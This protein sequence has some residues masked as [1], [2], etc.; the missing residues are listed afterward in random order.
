MD[1]RELSG[2]S[3]SGAAGPTCVG[4]AGDQERVDGAESSHLRGV[5]LQLIG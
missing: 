2:L 5:S 3:G 4:L 1:V